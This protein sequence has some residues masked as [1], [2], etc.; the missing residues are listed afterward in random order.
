MGTSNDDQASEKEMFKAARKA[1]ALDEMSAETHYAMGLAHQVVGQYEQSEAELI[2]SL[3]LNPHDSWVRF[4]F[5]GTLAFNGEPAAAIVELERAFA[6][7]P[8]DGRLYFLVALLSRAHLNAGH[9]EDAIDWARRAFKYRASRV[10]VRLYMAS[11]LGHLGRV[12][13]ARSEL[14]ECERLRPGSTESG[15]I[16]ARDTTIWETENVAKITAA[17][18]P[19]RNAHFLEGLRKAA[20]STE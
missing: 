18:D 2:R 7:N 20:G 12:D 19:M 6:L 1:L 4:A 13:E 15:L 16:G 10:E 17:T 11:A 8:N 14:E 9:Y 5:G 3:E